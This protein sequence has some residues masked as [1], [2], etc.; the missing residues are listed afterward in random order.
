MDAAELGS[1][2]AAAL[3]AA[4]PLVYAALGGL[5]TELTGMLNIALEGLISVGAFAAVTG[6][7][8]LAG[9]S[10]ASASASVLVA[11]AGCGVAASMAVAALYGII[12]IKGKANEFVTGLGANLLASGL[13][14]VVSAQVYRSKGVLSFA[15]PVLPSLSS[16][17]AGPLAVLAGIPVIGKAIFGQNALV[18]GSWLAALVIWAIVA[19]APFGLRLRAAGSNPKALRAVG[20][21]PE[22]SRFAAVLVSGAACGLSGACLSLGLAAYVP[23][24]SAGRGWIALVAIYLG[25]RKPWGVFAACLA[26]AA[27]DSFANYAQGSL[28]LPAEFIMALPYAVTLLALVAGALWKK[29]AGTSMKP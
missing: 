18:Y 26:F 1:V 22:R 29:L 24:I 2:L 15:L 10:G 28:K 17:G 6:A 25:G 14:V 3:A 16:G 9:V 13:I 23:N 7:A 5:L 21:S 8:A 19:K 12:T 20:L 27:A 11:G 4:A